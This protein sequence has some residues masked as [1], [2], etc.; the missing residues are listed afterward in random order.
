MHN[1]YSCDLV[2]QSPKHWA[3]DSRR[4]QLKQ[5]ADS[6]RSLMAH[7]LTGAPELRLPAWASNFSSGWALVSSSLRPVT[8]LRQHP[9]RLGIAL[10]DRL[11][12]PCAFRPSAFASWPS[13]PTGAWAPP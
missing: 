4:T 11:W 7:R 5:L 8:R 10:S 9:F 6:S 2:S 1:S 3:C 12:I 13:C